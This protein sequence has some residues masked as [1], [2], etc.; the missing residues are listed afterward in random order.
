MGKLN[1]KMHILAPLTLAVVLFMWFV[2]SSFFGIEGLTVVQQ[3][4]IA[5]FCYA[6]LMWMFEI[7]LPGQRV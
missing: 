4:T 1:V 3:R 5:I 7:I 2:P 6:A